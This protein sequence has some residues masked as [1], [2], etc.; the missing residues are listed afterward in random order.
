[1]RFRR[2][3]IPAP[4]GRRRLSAKL[5]RALLATLGLA[6]LV[7]MAYGAWAHWPRA[8]EFDYA[9]QLETLREEVARQAQ[10]RRVVEA[11]KIR[12]EQ[13]L[14]LRAVE[15]ESRDA[16]VERQEMEILALR[17]ELAFYQRL[18]DDRLEAPL[19][20]RGLAV[21]ESGQAG[22]FDV[23]FQAYR[24]GLDGSLDA[25]WVLEIDGREGD[26]DE[27]RQLG[28][29]ELGVEADARLTGLRLV[30]NVRVRISLPDGFAPGR[31]TI[32]LI[33]EDN[34]EL[35]PVEATGDWERLTEEGA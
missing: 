29:A 7:A 16:M 12:L 17:D 6:L 35:D 10:A 28:H 25:R 4:A 11:E 21:Q 26:S 19:G 30:R 2:P 23:I 22:V 3:R 5:G 15:V 24:P 27:V 20:I 8:A 32:R 33:P 1:M 18:A 14:R 13:R 9:A 31:V 34:E